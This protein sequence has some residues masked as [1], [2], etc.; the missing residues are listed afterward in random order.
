MEEVRI[1]LLSD[2]QPVSPCDLQNEIKRLLGRSHLY[3][4]P[5]L[6]LPL[7]HLASFSIKKKRESESRVGGPDKDPLDRLVLPGA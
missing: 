4:E 7:A 2:L 3:P 5:R 1:A 6:H